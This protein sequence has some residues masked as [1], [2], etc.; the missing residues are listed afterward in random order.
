MAYDE[1]LADRV[2]GALG[3]R[4]DVVEKKMFGGVAFMVLAML[5]L[6]T[7]LVLL[8]WPTVTY[9][10]YAYSGLR[11][12]PRTQGLI[13]TSLASGAVL[14]VWVFWSAMRRG[15]RALEALG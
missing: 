9:L 2:R 3:K 6:L 4:R 11:L 13:A 8:G 1:N 7:M 10:G 12:P 14:S 15:V 5:Y